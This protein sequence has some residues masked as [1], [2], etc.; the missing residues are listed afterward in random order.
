MIVRALGAQFFQQPIDAAEPQKTEIVVEAPRA[1]QK[2]SVL[3][4][5]ARIIT[6]KVDE[7]IPAGDV[8]VTH[9][10]IVSVEGAL[11][12]GIAHIK[13]KNFQ[14][15]TDAYLGGDGVP[16]P[17]RRMLIEGKDRIGR[18]LR[19]RERDAAAAAR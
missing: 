18:A 11:Y 19:A 17:V 1:R 5:G 16:G 8:L 4:S 14:E 3:L 15:R 6:M 10:R 9:I 13:V 12:G 7:V 2:G